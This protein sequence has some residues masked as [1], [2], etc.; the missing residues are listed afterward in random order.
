MLHPAAGTDDDLAPRMAKEAH[1]R[2]G[3][4]LG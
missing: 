3:D 2:A 4:A 1:D